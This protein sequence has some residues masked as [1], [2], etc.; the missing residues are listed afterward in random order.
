[1]AS[2]AAQRRRNSTD[3]DQQGQGEASGHAENG[4]HEWGARKGVLGTEMVGDWL[5]LL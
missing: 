4:L 3:I 1:M 5:R 2:H